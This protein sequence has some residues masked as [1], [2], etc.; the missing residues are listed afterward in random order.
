[1][2][3]Q[4]Q[5]A[6][7][8]LQIPQDLFDL[9]FLLLTESN[10]CNQGQVGAE[11]LASIG[12]SEGLSPTAGHHPAAKIAK[13]CPGYVCLEFASRWTH[14]TQEGCPRRPGRVLVTSNRQDTEGSKRHQFLHSI[15]IY[16]GG[17]HK[18]I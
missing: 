13:Q 2:H 4:T 10:H 6:I 8:G 12:W 5:Q 17:I 9:H 14:V 15:N 3:D 7:L 16:S 11:G 1:M 18:K